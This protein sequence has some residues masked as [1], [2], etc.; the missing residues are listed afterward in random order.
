MKTKL[1]PCPFCG[2]KGAI[3]AFIC[4]PPRYWVECSTP[5]CAVGPKRSNERDEIAERDAVAAW[6]R[7]TARR[8]TTT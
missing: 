7:R 3:N 6:N 8:G 1:K 5:G 2:G 4:D